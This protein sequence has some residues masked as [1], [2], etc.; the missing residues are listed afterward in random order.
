MLS[1]FPIMLSASPAKAQRQRGTCTVL[2]GLFDRSALFGLLVE[3]DALGLDL[4]APS[5]NT[6]HRLT[7]SLG[8]GPG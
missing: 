8:G 5:T 3:I 7:G 1:A 4:L 6:E 2:A